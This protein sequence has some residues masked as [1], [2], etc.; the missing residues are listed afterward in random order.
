MQ[1]KHGIYE[2]YIKR[3]L[4]IICSLL[5]IMFFGWLY[6]II[7]MLV[8]VKMGRPV[9]F[10]QPRPGL[11]DPKTGQE[12]IFDMY[13][14]RTMTDE[15]DE[16]G[17]LLPDNLRLGKFGK[18]LRRSSMDELLE[19]FNILKGDMS[20]IGPRPQ[21]VRDMVFM[22]KEVRMRHTVKPGLSGLAQVNGRNAVTWEQKFDWD[23]MYIEKVS[24]LGDFKIL[25]KTV[26]KV[27]GHGES[28]EELNVTDDYGDVLLKTG[29]VS[30]SR[31]DELQLQAKELI[32]EYQR[33]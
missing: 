1:R 10:K 23:L 33:S 6:I 16:N 3:L 11:I 20:I 9:V 21:L 19:V 30:K 2:R 25:I 7:A 18:A 5:T 15:R 13:K 17:N 28:D 22:S 31:Y 4:D 12:R 24:F 8:R 26:M 29:M 32:A 14:F 27:F